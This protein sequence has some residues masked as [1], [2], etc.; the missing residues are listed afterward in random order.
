MRESN[1]D[2]SESLNAPAIGWAPI[3]LLALGVASAVWLLGLRSWVPTW[4]GIP[5]TALTTLCFLAAAAMARAGVPARYRWSMVGGL[6]FSALGDAFLMQTRDYFVAGLGSF[7]VAHLCYLWALTSDSRLAQ[8]RLPFAVYGVAGVGLVSWLWPEIPRALRLPVALYAV[9][10]MTMAAQAASRALSKRVLAAA[11]AAVG[12][13][14]FVISDA[15][16]AARRFGHPSDW[17]HFIVLGTYFGAQA[18]L[19]LSVVLHGDWVSAPQP[20]ANGVLPRDQ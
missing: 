6:G 18:G 14:L 9:T 11:L 10:L 7:L 1:P 16:L 3:L 20:K 8:R 5:N 4:R 13:A 15:A 19:A 17:G 2:R 12:A